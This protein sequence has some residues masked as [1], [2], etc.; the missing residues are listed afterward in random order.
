MSKTCLVIPDIQAKPGHSLKHLGY[1]A[2]FIKE[3]RP[4]CIVQL[5]DLWD[6]PSLSSYDRGKKAAEGKRLVA[7]VRIGQLAAQMITPNIR[8]YR[9]KLIYTEGN[10]EYRI[11]R[12]ENDYP[13][14]EGALFSPVDYMDDL[15]WESYPF[16]QVAQWRGISFSHF[17][18]RTATGTTSAASQRNGASSALA[19]VRANMTTCIAGHKQGL[20]S[21]IFTLNDHRKRGI[22]AG[23]FY[24]HNEGYHSAQGHNYWRGVLML[25]NVKKGD[26]D[27]TEVSLGYLRRKYK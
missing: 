12:Y 16:L 9:P 5:G 14:L 6:I 11:Q 13:E 18:P 20:D 22:I 3:K 4:D 10:H 1:L 24:S 25:N 15:G 23:S 17:F 21:A 7:D 27:L 2:S 8:G 19:M 26:F